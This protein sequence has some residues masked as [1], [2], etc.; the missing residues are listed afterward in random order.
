VQRLADL[1]EAIRRCSHPVTDP[2]LRAWRPSHYKGV[3]KI[4]AGHL[5]EYRFLP[6]TMRVIACYFDDEDRVL[7]LTATV[8]HDHDRMQ[9]LIEE[10]GKA[11]AL[12]REER[13]EEED[14]P[15][16]D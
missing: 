12:Y 16:P 9:R 11:F 13:E 5:V 7:L 6:G 4:R 14:E 15:P 3:T 2:C 10:H 1:L 8:K